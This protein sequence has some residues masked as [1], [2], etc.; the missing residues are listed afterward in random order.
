[1]PTNYINKL[2]DELGIPV[3]TLETAWEQ[4]KEIIGKKHAEDDPKY[5]PFVTSVFKNIVGISTSKDFPEWWVN[6]G[7]KG[8]DRYLANKKNS[9]L[10][11]T[12]D[13]RGR[14]LKNVT[15]IK[16][17]KSKPTSAPKGEGST[18]KP[19]S[20]KPKAVETHED[21]LDDPLENTQGQVEDSTPKQEVPGQKVEDAIHQEVHE[22]PKLSLTPKVKRNRPPRTVYG[23]IKTAVK[24]NKRKLKRGL[25]EILSQHKDGA[26][27]I[28]K[29]VMGGKLSDEEKE[30]AKKTTSV[31]FTG[32]LGVAALGAMAF[33]GPGLST[34]LADKFLN[35]MQAGSESSDSPAVD[36]MHKYVDDMANWLETVDL[37]QVAEEAAKQEELKGKKNDSNA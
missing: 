31:L 3:K 36:P 1:M 18:N 35:R 37:E 25:G 34:I 30:H 12:Y 4:A 13:K 27:A 10:T 21:G 24:L 15:I 8:Q 32:L 28:S 5:W 22:E 7:P 19:K 23:K 14:L 2:S 11:K 20:S 33:A 29:L 6:L 16:T 9:K 17:G 26:K